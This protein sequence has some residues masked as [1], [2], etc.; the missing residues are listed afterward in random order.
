MYEIDGQRK[1]E[2][3]KESERE[4][5]MEIMLNIK[6]NMCMCAWR[7]RDRVCASMRISMREIEFVHH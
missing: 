3:K 7:E 5:N 4:I 1:K 2:R 6:N